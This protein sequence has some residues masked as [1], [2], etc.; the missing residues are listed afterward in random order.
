MVKEEIFGIEVD[1][2]QNMKKRFG[3]ISIGGWWTIEESQHQTNKV[4]N[5]F[6]RLTEQLKEIKGNKLNITIGV[7][8]SLCGHAIWNNMQKCL[9]RN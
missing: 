2:K 4:T 8:A 5:G 6:S 1:S 3:K 7:V 9:R